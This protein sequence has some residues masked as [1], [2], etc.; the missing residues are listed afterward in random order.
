MRDPKTVPI[1]APVVVRSIW[2]CAAHG[3]CGRVCVRQWPTNAPAHQRFRS[4]D[5][6]W[7]RKENTISIDWSMGWTD[8]S[9]IWWELSPTL[10]YHCQQKTIIYH[11]NEQTGSQTAKRIIGRARAH[12]HTHTHK[13]NIRRT[14]IG[15]TNSRIV[16]IE[17]W[18]NRAKRSSLNLH[19]ALKSPVT[20]D[21]N[22]PSAHWC[23][24]VLHR[25]ERHRP[26]QH[27]DATGIS[28]PSAFQNY[29]NILLGYQ[30]NAS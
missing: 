29:R 12:A 24:H 17:F 26:H 4:N 13:S 10:C 23:V 27:A 8:F 22:V 18:T 11:C 1:P 15:W 9:I 28:C 21:F 19:I 20:E 6:R 5:S 14:T 7:K 25:Y 16:W 3:A 30:A 2:I